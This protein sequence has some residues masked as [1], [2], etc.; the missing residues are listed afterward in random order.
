MSLTKQGKTIILLSILL[1]TLLT[2]LYLKSDEINVYIEVHLKDAAND[3]TP[4]EVML[5]WYMP[6][7]LV[8]KAVNQSPYFPSISRYS[9]SVN[10]TRRT[11]MTVW[12][13]DNYVDLKI[14]EQ[15]LYNYLEE[16]GNLQDGTVDITETLEEVGNDNTIYGPTELNVSI[17]E[18]N[19]TSGYFAVIIEPFMQNQSEYYVIYYGTNGKPI[20]EQNETIKKLIS[21]EYSMIN[22]NGYVRGLQNYS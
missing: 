21:K 7:D 5:S 12:Y 17:Y 15:E 6:P 11:M 19:E 22:K 2:A 1:L 18:S 14:G 9:G 4:P 20:D 8:N 16:H 3:P 10:Y 13:F